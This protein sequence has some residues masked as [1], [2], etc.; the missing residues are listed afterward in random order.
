MSSHHTRGLGALEEAIEECDGKQEEQP[1]N[2]EMKDDRPCAGRGQEEQ[3]GMTWAD[4]GGRR[5]RQPVQREMLMLHMH[6]RKNSQ[7]VQRR[8]QTDLKQV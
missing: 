3:P 8:K 7:S 2:A 5:N 4:G 1:G 6:S